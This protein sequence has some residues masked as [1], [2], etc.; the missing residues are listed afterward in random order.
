MKKNCLL[1]QNA[2]DKN[3]ETAYVE[4]SEND[5]ITISIESDTKIRRIG[6]INGFVKTPNLYASNNHIKKNKY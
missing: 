6:I 2:F 5:E 1:I 3:P 4:K